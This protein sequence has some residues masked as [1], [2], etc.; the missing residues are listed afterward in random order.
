MTEKSKRLIDQ[1]CA[2]ILNLYQRLPIHIVRGEGSLLYDDEGQA[3]L[4]LFSGIAVNNLGHGHPAIKDAIHHQ[5]EKHMHLSNYFASE[6]VIN[7]A[8]T[9]VKHSFASKV[10]F[11]NSGTEA[12]EAAIKLA[13]KYGLS[14]DSN[15][16]ELLSF[17]GSFHG[18]S[19]GGMTLTGQTRYKEAFKPN[20]P[21]V[22]HVQFDDVVD[23]NRKVSDHTCAFFIEIIQGEGGVTEVSSSFMDELI[24][25]SKK[26]D[27]LIIV[28]EIQ[29]GL[30][31]AGDLFAYEKYDFTP[32]ALTLAKSL[33][34]GLPL[35]AL[36]VAPELEHILVPGDHGSTFGGNPVSC[37]AG[38]AVLSIITSDGFLDEVRK[39][40]AYL[41]NRLSELSRRYPHHIKEVRGRGLIIGVEMHHDYATKI[42]DEALKHHLLLNVTH[43][44]VLR[45]LPALNIRQDE[46]DSFL[47]ILEICI[48]YILSE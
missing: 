8:E 19:T 7:L 4:D 22:S 32:H 3:Y 25:L 29:T 45:L 9:L 23:L 12:I 46:L 2:S 21:N 42:K 10:F 5:I 41:L 38:N 40:S 14:K 15:K 39:K 48:Q 43:G 35:G 27:F 16:T 13:R 31:R 11:S 30:G 24:R 47:D 18:R 1:D 28:D 37:A 26:H 34:G 33:G 36:L 44:N 17:E 20:L 6:P